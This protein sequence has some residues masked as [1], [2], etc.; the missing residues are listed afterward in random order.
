VA[1]LH[2]QANQ[3]S[4]IMP[5]FPDHACIGAGP[6]TRSSCVRAKSLTTNVDA[7]C[8]RFAVLSAMPKSRKRPAVVSRERSRRS[9]HLAAEE[10]K[11]RLDAWLA[12]DGTALPPPTVWFPAGGYDG[13]RS[14]R[15][16]LCA[17]RPEQPCR[18]G[19]G[20]ETAEHMERVTLALRARNR[21]DLAR[22]GGHD[23]R[24]TSC[25]ASP[26]PDRLYCA[27]HDSA[28]C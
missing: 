9:Q 23:A 25:L 12:P 10:I 1:A 22:C 8:G 15:C 26:L 21:G 17:A 11:R 2:T 28:D 27:A 24:G 3:S 5:A 14:E 4:R 20:G 19:T 7:R 13:I 18:N 16:P 6:G